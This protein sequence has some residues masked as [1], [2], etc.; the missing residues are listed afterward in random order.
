M[1]ERHVTTFTD[2][3]EAYDGF[4]TRTA[5]ILPR[6]TRK[7]SVRRVE[8]PERHVEWQ[9]QRYGSGLHLAASVERW[10]EIRDLISF[11]GRAD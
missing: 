5:E 8:T 7:G 1:S 10:D 11:P 3:P 6:H 4:G 9:R 2:A